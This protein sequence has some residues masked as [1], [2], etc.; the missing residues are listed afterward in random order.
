VKPI[1]FLS[2]AR[3]RYELLIL[4][5]LDF[6]LYFVWNRWETLVLFSLGYIWNWAASQSLGYVLENRRYRFSLIKMVYNL[7]NLI[8]VPFKKFHPIIKILPKSL[9]AGLFWFL[10]LH[11]ANSELPWW[12]IFIGSFVYEIIQ[13]DALLIKQHHDD[14]PPLPK[15]ELP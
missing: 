3:K 15:D 4:L 1:V 12:P 5:I 9:P 6:G 14:L 10:I 13:F 2:E 11:F 8:L 7:Q